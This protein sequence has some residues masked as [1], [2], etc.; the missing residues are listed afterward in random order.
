[1]PVLKPVRLTTAITLS[2]GLLI[3]ASYK[4][5]GVFYEMP[6]QQVEWQLDTTLGGVQFFHATIACNG[7][8]AIMIKFNNQN[9]YPVQVSWKEMLT[10][11]GNR[12]H[13]SAAGIKK[14]VINPGET[15]ASGCNENTNRQLLVLPDKS[16]L[17]HAIRITKFQFRDLIVSKA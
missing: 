2:L 12:R 13:E 4:D 16:V 11:E 17:T 9:N 5:P 10:D 15:A 3:L 14:L 1:M 6:P 8:Q 7:K